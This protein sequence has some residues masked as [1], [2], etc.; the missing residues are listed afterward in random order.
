MRLVVGRSLLPIA[1]GLAA[2][3]AGALASG[4]LLT[5]LL[6]DVQPADPG[7]LLAIVLVLGAVGTMGS[8]LPARRAASVDP[9]VVLR[10]E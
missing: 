7:V 6:F 1:I 9:L 8:W 2:G 3:V 10:N 4:R 5:S